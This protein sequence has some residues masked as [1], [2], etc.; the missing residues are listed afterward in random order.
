MSRYWGNSHD[1]KRKNTRR[2]LHEFHKTIRQVVLSTRATSE[3]HA[4][5]P[6]WQ[7]YKSW[8]L[9]EWCIVTPNGMYEMGKRSYDML[10]RKPRYSAEALV[11][12]V[13]KDKSGQGVLYCQAVNGGRREVIFKCL[14][15]ER[16]R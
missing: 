9:R 16:C 10:K 5:G 1:T 15:E 13:E 4:D 7:I 14:N 11:T 8:D 6:L 12:G 2:I 3:E